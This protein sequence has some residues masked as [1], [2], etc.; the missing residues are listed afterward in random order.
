MTGY[1][2]LQELI[3]WH[4]YGEPVICD[5]ARIEPELLHAA[6]E[7]KEGLTQIEV[8]AIARL[9]GCPASVISCPNLVK[10]DAGRLRHK[11]MFR[12][13]CCIYFELKRMSREGNRDAEKYLGWAEREYQMFL[14]AAYGDGL[15]YGHYLG[16]KERLSQYVSFATP[17]PKRRG[18]ARV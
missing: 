8:I 2:N 11:K 5:H 13:V 16:I 12:E 18:L 17:K 1:P 10:L 14:A 3:T 7:G 6:L 9:Y 15:T 4:P